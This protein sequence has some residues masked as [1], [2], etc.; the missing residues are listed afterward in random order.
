MTLQELYDSLPKQQQDLLTTDLEL[1]KSFTGFWFA[2]KETITSFLAKV[3]LE[4]KRLEG[5]CNIP[6][7]TK[8]LQRVRDFLPGFLAGTTTITIN[9]KSYTFNDLAD[10]ILH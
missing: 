3:L 2:D 1:N 6:A 5:R 4:A 8:E 7:N 9:G 10:L